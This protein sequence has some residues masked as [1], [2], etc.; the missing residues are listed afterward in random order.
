VSSPELDAADGT[1]ITEEQSIY[2]IVQLSFV[3]V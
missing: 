3:T 1:V 2:E